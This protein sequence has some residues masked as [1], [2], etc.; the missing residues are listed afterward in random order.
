MRFIQDKGRDEQVDRENQNPFG[1][2][3][4]YNKLYQEYTDTFQDSR[5][6]RIYI[7]H[8]EDEDFSTTV[9][10]QQYFEE[11]Q[12]SQKDDQYVLP[13]VSRF[14]GEDN[15]HNT[16]DWGST[17]S[18]Q[19]STERSSMG[20]TVNSSKLGN[21]LQIIVYQHP[22]IRLVGEAPREEKRTAN[23]KD[24]ANT[25]YNTNLRGC[26]E[27]RMGDQLTV[28]EGIRLLEPRGKKS[29]YKRGTSSALL[30]DLAIQIQD[31]C[32]TYNIQTIYQ[33]IQGIHNTEADALSRKKIPFHES[34]IP[35]KMF[36]WIEANWG[37]RRVDAF[38]ARHNH[39]LTEYWTLNQD[40]NAT[41]IDAFQ[42]D[43]RIKGLYL[44]PPWKLIP[45]VLKKIKE[46]KLKECGK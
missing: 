2:T 23:P 32:N 5:I 3:R 7:Q 44:Y 11:N 18:Y 21:E 40:H 46:Q 19:I 13:V 29:I 17:A 16:S 6:P 4:F 27:H 38:A 24:E 22:R 12:T 20:I 15:V 26:V 39:Q 43:W 42:Q 45:Q 10:D 41:A 37:K 8:Q 35:K 1:K 36:Q 34:A 9:K 14:V 25:T 28:S 30:Q 31:I 33:H